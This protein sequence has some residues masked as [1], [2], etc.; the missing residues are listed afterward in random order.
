MKV[1]PLFLLVVVLI[2]T[3]GCDSSLAKIGAD[4]H[5]ELVLEWR[6]GRLE[7]LMARDGYLNL[8][9]LFWLTDSES[10]FGSGEDNDIRFP[11]VAADAIGTFELSDDGVLMQINPGVD[12]RYEGVPVRSLFL[13]D[14]TTDN[15][16]TITHRSLAWLVIK[17]AGRFGVRLR[18]FENPILTA[19]PPL[20]YFPI[21]RDFR[22]EGTLVPYPEPRVVQVDTVIEGL[23]WE[24]ESP[25][26]VRF[27]LAGETYELEAYASGDRLFFVFGDLTN[28][29][30]TYPA[31]RFL[32]ADGPDESGVTVLDFN[33]SYSP[34]CAFNDFSTCPVAT[35][36]NRLKTAITAGE[37]Y[38][39]VKQPDV[40][41]QR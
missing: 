27:D 39:P 38:D 4:E 16:I 1:L 19:F 11:A 30:Q 34:P 17:R 6:N 29:R 7:R 40:I 37:K 12:V 41:A 36:R 15:P 21:S 20:E 25:G 8:A 18:D 9:G 26:V 35:P 3:A 2:V 23:G 14:D 32:Y 31:G 33:L 22:V 28:G 13:S 24:P 5:E 10:T